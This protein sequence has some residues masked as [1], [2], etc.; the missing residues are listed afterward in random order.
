MTHTVAHQ[1]LGDLF[2][3][4]DAPRALNQRHHHAISHSQDGFHLLPSHQAYDD[5]NGGNNAFN[6]GG[7]IPG[8]IVIDTK[9]F[10]CI[11]LVYTL[12]EVPHGKNTNIP[13]RTPT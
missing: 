6:L 4:F 2:G 9:I 3:R 10:C 7:Q 5:R 11:I 8:C 12:L 13:D 1:V